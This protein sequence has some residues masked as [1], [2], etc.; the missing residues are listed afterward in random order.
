MPGDY[1]ILSEKEQEILNLLKFS[2]EKLNL[3]EISKLIGSNLSYTSQLVSKLSARSLIR[4]EQK[5]NR[6][7]YIILESDPNNRDSNFPQ[8]K[9]DTR[10]L[11]LALKL[12]SFFTA[13]AN[14]L[15][16]DIN[17]KLLNSLTSDEREF[18]NSYSGRI[19]QLEE[20]WS[21]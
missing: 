3:T 18:I 20:A 7:K 11:N 6:S 13:H 4:M 14:A 19:E 5:D 12:I 16:Q 2:K 21:D 15:P 9:I 17:E 8:Y 1:V 10:S